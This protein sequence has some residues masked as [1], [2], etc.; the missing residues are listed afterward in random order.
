MNPLILE[1]NSSCSFEMYDPY[2]GS[3]LDWRESHFE[4]P[5][6]DEEE[7]DPDGVRGQRMVRSLEDFCAAADDDDDDFPDRQQ[8]MSLSAV[9]TDGPG[10]KQRQN[11]RRNTTN[12][13][14]DPEEKDHAA[15]LKTKLLSAFTNVKNGWV[16]KSAASFSYGS[17]T[18]LLGVSYKFTKAEFEER[19]RIGSSTASTYDRFK[20]DFESRLW[21]TYRK[22]FPKLDGSQLTNDIGWGC[23]MRSGQ[24][25]L[26]Q[27]FVM[28]F[29]GRGWVWK[30]D[31]SQEE[32]VVHRRIIRYFGDTHHS[33]CPFSVQ[34]LVGIGRKLGRN[35]G[36][37]YGPASVSAVLRDA[38]HQ[39]DTD[40]LPE[41]KDLCIYVAMDGVLFVK[42]VLDLCTNNVPAEESENGEISEE[43]GAE[44]SP[45]SCHRSAAP[46]WR[47]VIVLVPL[48]LGSDSLNR[49]YVPCLQTILC[50]PLCIGIIGGRPKHSMYFIGFQDDKLIL[51]DPHCSQ[52]CVN[53]LKDD[54][55]VETFHCQYPRKLSFSKMDPTC[56]LGFYCKTK[57]D[58][59]NFLLEVPKITMPPTQ[60]TF[61]LFHFESGS[62]AEFENGCRNLSTSQ[63]TQSITLV[64]RSERGSISYDDFTLL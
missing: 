57:E 64:S 7:L 34:T 36:D 31:A 9:E 21:L 41:L 46:N 11:N 39:A 49:I 56:T 51:L 45:D 19:N 50:H 40:L 12:G 32:N 5:A 6:V 27:A 2:T 15:I 43:T 17:T 55:P 38:L 1:G 29:L 18:W 47:S 61:P 42:D 3:P 54:F 14:A 53:V 25:L 30:K 44:R 13:C 20:L 59:D 28:H 35:P 24:M 8:P 60:E 33:L 37:W 26:A 48:R 4:G 22:D 58:F 16:V 10:R 23:M 62:R 63:I 52:D